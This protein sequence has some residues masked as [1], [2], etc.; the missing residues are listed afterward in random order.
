MSSKL[1][2]LGQLTHSLQS[3]VADLAPSAQTYIGVEQSLKEIS[4]SLQA[5]RLTLQIVGQDMAQAEKLQKML[6]IHSGLEANYQF[7]TAAIPPIPTLILQSSL[8]STVL[9]QYKLE[10]P[11]NQIIGRNPATAQLVLSNS[12]HLTSSNHAEFRL[13]DHHWQIRDAGSS[14][15][16]F[17][18]D[19]SDRLQDW[20]TLKT[21]DRICLGSPM[22][23]EGSA[24]FLV[25]I[26]T[27]NDNHSGVDTS[28]ILDCNIICLVVPPQPLAENFQHLLKTIRTSETSKFFVII[29]RPEHIA[30]DEFAIIINQ[31]DS[32]V[33]HQLQGIPFGLFSLYFNHH[34]PGNTINSA[35]SQPELENF[36]NSLKNLS[37]LGAETILS[38]WAVTKLCKIIDKIESI[39]LNTEY[40]TDKQPSNKQF[41]EQNSFYT[42]PKKNLEKTCKKLT[43]ECEEFFG[44][45]RI[46]L[47]QSK[48]NFLDEFKQN[49]IGYKL[50][51]FNKQLQPQIITKGDYKNVYLQ[52]KVG[53]SHDSVHEALVDLCHSEMSKW[54]TDEWMKIRNEY[55]GGGLSFFLADSFNKLSS[56]TEI[57]PSKQDFSISQKLNIQ[58]I[59]NTSSVEPDINFKYRKIGFFEH[60]LKNGKS[61]VFGSLTL[62]M[63]VTF[64]FKGT[65]NS[66]GD[67]KSDTEIKI[68]YLILFLVP[69]TI[70][71]LWFNFKQDQELKLKEATEKLRKE[72]KNH[73]QS[74][75]EWMT[76]KLIQR[77]EIIIKS[78]ERHFQE[79]LE[80]AQEAYDIYLNKQ[81]G[82]LG[83]Q[84][85]TQA[86]QGK[87]VEY[88]N[89]LYHLKKSIQNEYGF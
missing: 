61:H 18:N 82:Q 36:H 76:E 89:R 54:V 11:H 66:G 15:G 3:L 28:K 58:T 39:L 70:S 49:S 22:Q 8:G 45:V 62:T 69:F 60:L 24:N 4:T 27:N 7:R 64:L 40:L 29:E 14:N 6:E 71:V 59:L 31:I 13:L 1:E 33:K 5:G 48:S 86:E 34:V 77:I 55:A 19:D 50:Q 12:F 25:E 30:Y 53:F 9:T 10:T 57:P 20:Y 63:I 17:V 88:L 35:L 42:D 67:V 79:A 85:S 75:T 80:N 41:S 74:Y 26:K 87:T 44:Q 21:G 78:E 73:Y 16:T 81:Q 68:F 32:S 43:N 51:D 65:E 37:T 52:T 72:V 83:L 38:K 46:E 23:A 47:N 84:N 56:I 2:I